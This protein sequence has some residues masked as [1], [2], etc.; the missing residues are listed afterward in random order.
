MECAERTTS[1][2]PSR[3]VTRAPGLVELGVVVAEVGDVV[4]GL[5]R[6]QRAAV[7]AQVEGVEVVAALGP[8]V[9]VP[10]LEEVVGE[11]VEVQ[12]RLGGRCA[13]AAR[14]TSVA[15]TSPSSSDGSAWSR[16]GTAHRGRR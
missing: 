8:P 9:G 3:S 16:R 14:C 10:G 6:A 15:T 4:G 11:A 1:V 12:H 2:W 5:V 7:L 13:A